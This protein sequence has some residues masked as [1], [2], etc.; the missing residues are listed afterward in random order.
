M[1]AKFGALGV[2]ARDAVLG[3]N[4]EFRMLADQ[5][6]L[7]TLDLSVNERRLAKFR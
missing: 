1:A 7:P 2:E 5:R 3:C 4:D 6:R